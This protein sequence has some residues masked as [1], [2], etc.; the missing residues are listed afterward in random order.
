MRLADVT[1]KRMRLQHTFTSPVGSPGV[2]D[3]GI[4][5]GGPRRHVDGE[6]DRYLLICRSTTEMFGRV[7]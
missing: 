1:S 2:R 3:Q 6:G 5:G 7:H 4:P